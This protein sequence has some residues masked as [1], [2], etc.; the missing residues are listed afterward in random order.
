MCPFYQKE[1]PAR[2]KNCKSVNVLTNTQN[3]QTWLPCICHRIKLL[4][5]AFHGEYQYFLPLR[6]NKIITTL[7]LQSRGVIISLTLWDKKYMIFT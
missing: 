5:H 3:I 6:V 2:L 1:L 4:S 7:N